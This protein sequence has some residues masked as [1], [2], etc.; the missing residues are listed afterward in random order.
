MSTHWRGNQGDRSLRPPAPISSPGTLM[1]PVLPRAPRAEHGQSG[2]AAGR[3]QHPDPDATAALA[4]ARR[5]RGGRADVSTASGSARDGIGTLPHQRSE[6]GRP[7]GPGH[8]LP[9]PRAG[10]WPPAGSPSRSDAPLPPPPGRRGRG[11]GLGQPARAHRVADALRMPGETRSSPH[12]QGH[13][14]PT[15]SSPGTWLRRRR[16][17]SKRRSSPPPRTQTGGRAGGARRPTFPLPPGKVRCRGRRLRCRGRR[18]GQ[19]GQ[20]CRPG[21]L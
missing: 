4:A 8:L 2:S 15:P 6:S 21:T 12:E 17:A 9:P 1:K 7:P 14:F 5:S 10:R 3:H 19:A 13:P 16:R 11:R 20:R 18:T